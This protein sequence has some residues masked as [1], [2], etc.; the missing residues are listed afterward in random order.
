LRSGSAMLRAQGVRATFIKSSSIGG[1]ISAIPDDRRLPQ[2][3]SG[4]SRPFSRSRSRS[5]GRGTFGT[6]T[7]RSS[8]R[9]L[10]EPPMAGTVGDRTARRKPAYATSR[11]AA[12]AR[13]GKAPAIDRAPCRSSRVVDAAAAA[14]GSL[15]Q[16]ADRDSR[17]AK[18][19]VAPRHSGRVGSRSRFAAHG[20]SLFR[21]KVYDTGALFFHRWRAG[22]GRSA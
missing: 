10:R 18:I 6:S 8:S 11:G 19:R 7:S 12:T 17:R 20:E 22:R 5:R 4:S 2:P 1:H 3:R 21:P 16:G 9:R 13:G 14:A 15:R